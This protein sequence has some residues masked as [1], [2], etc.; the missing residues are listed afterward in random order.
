MWGVGWVSRE[1]IGEEGRGVWWRGAHLEPWNLEKSPITTPGPKYT[2]GAPLALE[3]VKKRP[4]FEA[5]LH[6]WKLAMARMFLPLTT[7]QQQRVEGVAVRGVRV[8]STC[9]S[10]EGWW[11]C[12]HGHTLVLGVGVHDHTVDVLR[13]RVRLGLRVGDGAR[14]PRLGLHELDLRA[15]RG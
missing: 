6:L 8:K 11:V 1:G 13:D 12:V 5:V 9:H 14:V 15:M 3:G 7:E 4:C 10:E 2:R